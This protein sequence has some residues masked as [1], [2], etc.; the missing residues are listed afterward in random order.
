MA[1][2][3]LRVLG[4]AHRGTISSHSILWTL[5]PFW[6]LDFLCQPEKIPTLFHIQESI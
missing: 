2:E 1:E 5:I 3:K 4:A 6:G